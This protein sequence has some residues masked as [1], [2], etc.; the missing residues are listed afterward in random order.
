RTPARSGGG[1]GGPAPAASAAPAELRA[2]HP[3]CRAR[4]AATLLA[5]RLTPPSQRLHRG[6]RGGRRGLAERDSRRWA[7]YAACRSGLLDECRAGIAG[8]TT[9]TSANPLRP[10]RPLR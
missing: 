3:R 10:P 8:P 1:G 7:G 4:G 9:T 2:S 6:G 5:L